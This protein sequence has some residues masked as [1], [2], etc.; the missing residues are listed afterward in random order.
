MKVFGIFVK[1]MTR[2]KKRPDLHSVG[3]NPF[4]E[5]LIVEVNKKVYDVINKFGNGD[6][7]VYSMESTP[8]TK[9]FEVAGA[10]KRVM[11]LPVRSKELLLYFMHS[12]DSGMDVLW[13]DRV[14][15][16]KAYG[17]KSVNT[18]KDAVRA[19]S[20]SLFIYPH[21]SIKDVYWINPHYFFKGNRVTKYKE[22]VRFKKQ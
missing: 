4:N 21:A 11:E 6:A 16:M 3:N 12:I 19:L 22:K 13:I 7:I 18:F 8:Y 20:D 1:D 9:V 14:G 10:K 17:I 15:Y 2:I 5:G